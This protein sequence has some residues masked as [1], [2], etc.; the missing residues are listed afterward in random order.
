MVAKKLETFHYEKVTLKKSHWERQ[1]AELIE[2]Y[3][4]IDNEDLLHY[5]RALAKIPDKGTGLVGWYGDNASTF[6]QKLSAMA[7]LY[8][9]TK[10][11]RLKTKVLYLADEWGKCLERSE[12]VCDI[13]DTYVYDKLMGGFLDLYEILDYTPA[14]KYIKKLTQSAAR[15][16]PRTISRDGLQDRALSG[17]KMIEWYTLP[18]HLIRA[19]Q[20]TGDETYW[21]FAKEWEYTYYYDKLAKKDFHIGPRHAYSHVNSLSSAAKFYEATGDEKYLTVLKNGYEEILTHHSFATGGYGPAECLFAEEEGYLGDSLKAN[22]DR[23]RIHKEYRNFGD[24]IVTRDD[25]WG[26]CEVSCCAWAVFKLTC[27][28]MTFTGEA[29]YG[30]WAE[31][32]LYNGT[33]GQPPITKEGKVMYYADYFVNGG[34]KTVEDRRLHDN[35]RSFEWQCCTGTF[36]QDV[37]EY[38]NLLYYKDQSGIYV[39]QYLPSKVAFEI[40]S[41]PI[42]LENLSLYPK[43]PYLDFVIHTEGKTVSDLNFRIPSWADGNN[44]VKINGE[45]QE[46]E[47]IPGTWLKLRREWKEGDRIEI[48]FPFRLHFEKADEYSP[49]IA[50]L[51]YG[52][53]VLVSDKMA[54]F[55]GNMENPEQWIKPSWREGYSYCFETLPGHV[56]GYDWLTRKFY[57]Y[58]EVPELEWY[59]MYSRLEEKTAKLS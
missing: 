11:E 14:L 55:Q 46:A 59:Y 52:P 36:P 13:N 3:L 37:A 49:D 35:G 47:M 45:K 24:S 22:W 50:A 4:G 31:K 26:S 19:W 30:D 56:K 51:M 8:L 16:F 28:L 27:Y 6:G 23:D 53:L 39:A 42:E 58:Y 17:A 15:R 21:E 29:R 10:D 25:A 34:I 33:G 40:D 1:R 41:R 32:L 54:V 9:N 20:I 7:R 43:T 18:E 57:P 12:K 5:F 44:W 38:V 2:T 48:H